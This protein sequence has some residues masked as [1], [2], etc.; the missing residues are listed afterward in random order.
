M[1]QSGGREGVISKSEHPKDKPSRIQH[2]RQRLQTHC[3][4]SISSRSRGNTIL[5]DPFRVR[6]NRCGDRVMDATLILIDNEAELA[7]GRALVDRLRNSDD[8]TDIARLE[9]QAALIAAYEQRRWPRRPP[10][11]AVLIRHLMD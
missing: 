3:E 4:P 6:Q 1:A 2:Q 11:A 10:S 9:A 7:R 5:R 8:L